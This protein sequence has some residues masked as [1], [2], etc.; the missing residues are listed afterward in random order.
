MSTANQETYLELKA[1]LRSIDEAVEVAKKRE[2]EQAIMRIQQTILEYG[3]TAR[4]IFGRR[5][6]NGDRDRRYG[7]V[8][9][10]YVNPTTGET[11]TGRGRPPR[12]IAGQNF[13][14]F[15]IGRAA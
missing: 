9:A 13:D 1:R 6:M 2:T 15:L 12:W 10:K 8:R 7:R 3:L 4:D 11:W 5:K 14:H